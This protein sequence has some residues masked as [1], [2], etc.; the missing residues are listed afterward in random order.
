LDGMLVE[1]D[2][3]LMYIF[4]VGPERIFVGKRLR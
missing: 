4:I 2:M 3:I 1:V